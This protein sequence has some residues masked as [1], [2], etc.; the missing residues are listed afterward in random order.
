[1]IYEMLT[2]RD[3]PAFSPPSRFG[4]GDGGLGHNRG[5]NM[6]SAIEL[7]VG[8]RTLRGM[9][10]RPPGNAPRCPVAAIYH[11]FT[12]EKTESHFIFVKLSRALAAAGLASVR[13]DFG[14]SGESDGDFGE[15]TFHGEVMEAK[16]ILD[17]ARDL[18]F[19]DL[20]RTF[21]VGLSMGGAVASVVAGD[22]PAKV[23]AMVLW[24]PAG[25]MPELIA[26]RRGAE[27]DSAL[28]SQGRL[29]IGGHWLGGDF[30]T[31]LDQWDVYDRA[32]RFPGP[33][34]PAAR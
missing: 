21:L 23:R 31:D 17:Y 7:E 11:G 25:N 8:G 28:R 5:D 18:P 15:M 34:A 4:K 26:A 27:A 12:G 3:F 33:G 10:H 19:A 14:G 24:A 29:D 13:F 2:W 6:Q 22:E 30:F 32:G 1:M 20:S 16:A 9:L